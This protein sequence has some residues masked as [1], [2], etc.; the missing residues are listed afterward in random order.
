M[1]GATDILIF[2]YETDISGWGGYSQ[3]NE[4]Y[5]YL[6]NQGFRY[7]CIED[8]ENVSWLQVGQDYVRQGIHEIDSYQD[9]QAV[10]A[11]EQ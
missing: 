5:S 3:E 9:Y 8:E 6:W 2:P 1:T 4:K 10:M 7:F 11:L